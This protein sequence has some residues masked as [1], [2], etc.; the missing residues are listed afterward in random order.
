M[1]I[2]SSL[3]VAEIPAATY[4]VGD[5]VPLI[6]IRG[7]SVVRDGYGEAKLK[8]IL[9]M[10]DNSASSGA[11]KIVVKN[12]NWVDEMSNIALAPSETFL[13]NDGAAVQQGQDADL[14]PNSGWSVSAV[15]VTGVT[16]TTASDLFCLIDIDYP[17]VAAVQNPRQ[18]QGNP[19]TIDNNYATA[20]TNRGSGSALVWTTHNVDF[21]KAGSKYLITEVG[22]RDAVAPALGFV[23]ISGAASQAGLERIIPCNTATQ[24]GIKFMFDYAT[25]LV[26]G[27]M[28]IGLAALGTAGTSTGYVYFDFVK[29]A[30]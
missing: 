14:Y 7:P 20:I 4:A 26:K 13:S 6:L 25:P 9:T 28:N 29:K 27:P 1:A 23:A 16:T 8:R 21:L 12:S 11:F 24:A 10:S 18:V 15:C 17:K 5:S 22:Y 2:D 3:F 30:R 19:V